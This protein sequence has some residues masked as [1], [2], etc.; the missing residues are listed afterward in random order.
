M[1]TSPGDMHHDLERLRDRTEITDLVYRLGVILDEG[2]FDEMQQLLVE[3]VAVRTPGGGAEGREA[4][5]AQAKRTHPPEQRFQHVTTNVLVDLD[6][7]RA[8]VRANLLVHITTPGDAPTDAPAPPLR[9]TLGEVYRFEVV[10]TPDGWRISRL[11]NDRLWLSGTLPAP[12][13]VT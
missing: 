3:D 7:D 9:T 2:R 6:V 8:T 1:S 13:R 10:R 11:E 12:T 5:I 4:V